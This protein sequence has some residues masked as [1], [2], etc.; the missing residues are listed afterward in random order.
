MNTVRKENGQVLLAAD[1]ARRLVFEI[2]RRAGCR[3]E[4]A[5]RIASRL[6]EANLRGHESHGIIRTARYVQWLGDGLLRANQS[7][8]IERENDVLAIID[9]NYGFGQ[10]IGEETVDVGLAKAKR[11]GVAVTAL[12]NSGHLGCIGDWALRAAEAEVASVHFVNVRGSLLVAPFGG[13]ERRGG[14]SPF[15]CGVPVPG[16]EPIILDFATSL[17]AEGKALVALRGGAPLPD[18]ALVGPDG[19]YSDDPRVLSMG[20]RQRGFTRTPTKGPAPSP[21]SA[22][23]R[24]PG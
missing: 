5:D 2:F 19:A 17:V 8:T 16:G 21:P 10:T 3:T 9:G 23:T 12:K 7:I 15:C 14:T 11:Q 20:L 22:A 13:T 1:G 24:A 6:V 18:D 4:E